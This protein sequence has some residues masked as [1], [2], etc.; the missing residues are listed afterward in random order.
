VLHIS[1]TSS[2]PE[3]SSVFQRWDNPEDQSRPA[4]FT[5][6]LPKPGYGPGFSGNL[7]R[8]TQKKPWRTSLRAIRLA[9]P[10]K[11]TPIIR[12]RHAGNASSIIYRSLRVPTLLHPMLVDHNRSAQLFPPVRQT[13]A[14]AASSASPEAALLAPRVVICQPTVPLHQ[15]HL[16]YHGGRSLFNKASQPGCGR[17][18]H[19]RIQKARSGYRRCAA[20]TSFML[21]TQYGSSVQ[22][23]AMRLHMFTMSRF[24]MCMG[25]HG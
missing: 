6:M 1:V 23:C 20:N 4:G 16:P 15:N 8:L 9:E 10:F 21:S 11:F 2:L 12:C 18:R 3:A 14:F 17:R 24:F 25:H 5:A 13:S 22:C 7:L 19:F